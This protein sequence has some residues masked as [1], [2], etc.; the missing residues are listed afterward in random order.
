MLRIV[1]DPGVL[2]AAVLSSRG[3]PARLLGEWIDGGFELIS[4]PLL[5]RE[6]ETVLMR[7]KFR[8]HLSEEEVSEYLILL[9]KLSIVIKDPDERV[10]ATPDP[11]DDYLVA[12]AQ[13]ASAD[14]LVSGDGH[15]TG[16]ADVLPPVITPKDLAARLGV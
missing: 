1:I 11:K 4:S 5:L 12:L 3:S 8:P 9:R 16:L 7:K 14:F 2:I 15:L 10:F 13:K 6:L